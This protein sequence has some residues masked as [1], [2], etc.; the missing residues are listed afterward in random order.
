[1]CRC[2]KCLEWQLKSLERNASKL[3]YEER[4]VVFSCFFYDYRGRHLSLKYVWW[5]S[6]GVKA[7]AGRR[8]TRGPDETQ[9]S[10]V[11]EPKY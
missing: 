1:M 11:E 9:R 10:I 8:N 3:Y 4:T 7:M 2:L 5:T 6:L